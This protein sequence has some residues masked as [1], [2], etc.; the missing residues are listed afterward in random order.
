MTT[1]TD[2][3]EYVINA[4]GKRLGKV[5]TEAA[6]ILNGKNSPQFAAHIVPPVTVKIEDARLL[7][8][9]E[10]KQSE[11]YQSYSGHPGGRKEER[12][13]HLAKRLGFAE[14]LRRTINGMLPKNKLQKLKMQNLTITE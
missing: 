13:D 8:I 7:D 14:V 5:A 1:T 6:S 10:G 11:I 12:L 2:K 3:I 9:P 4:N